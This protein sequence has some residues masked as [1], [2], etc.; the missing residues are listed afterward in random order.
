MTSPAL[1]GAQGDSDPDLDEALRRVREG[2]KGGGS[3]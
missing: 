2:G 3:R 1:L